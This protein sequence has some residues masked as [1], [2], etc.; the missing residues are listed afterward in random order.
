MFKAENDKNVFV[1]NICLKSVGFI[2]LV[3]FSEKCGVY[4]FDIC[5]TIYL[6]IKARTPAITE[7]GACYAPNRKW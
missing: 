7:W 1:W 2:F 4:K 3:K 5:L 6:L